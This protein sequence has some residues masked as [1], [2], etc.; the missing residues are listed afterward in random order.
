MLELILI[1]DRVSY[2]AETDTD[3]A[4]SFSCYEFQFFENTVIL[5]VNSFMNK[6]VTLYLRI[7]VFQN[8]ILL[9]NSKLRK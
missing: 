8:R 5:L 6:G 4:R 9:E 2:L 1:K 3:I 7:G